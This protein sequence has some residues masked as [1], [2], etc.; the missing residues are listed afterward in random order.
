MPE[1][2]GFSLVGCSGLV[3][4][5]PVL[6]GGGVFFGLVCSL[7]IASVE[8]GIRWRRPLVSV[9]EHGYDVGGLV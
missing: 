9:C 8:E 6:C 1:L 5:I 7:R 3:A 2:F 4:L